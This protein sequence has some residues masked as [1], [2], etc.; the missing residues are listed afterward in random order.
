MK[1]SIITTIAVMAMT[2]A[3]GFSAF[4]ATESADYN[5]TTNLTRSYGEISFQTPASWGEPTA[6]NGAFVWT[7]PEGYVMSS[8]SA[9]AGINPN[10]ITN[11]EITTIPL[12]NMAAMSFAATNIQLGTLPADGR[13]TCTVTGTGAMN[14]TSG[15]LTY[16]IVNSSTGVY[17][18]QYFA[19]AAAGTSRL[20]DFTQVVNSINF[21]TQTTTAVATASTQ[22]TNTTKVS[23][24]YKNALK[25]AETYSNKMHMSKQAVYDQ[26]TSQYGG[27]FSADAAQY[28][29][30]NVVADWNA[31][32]LKSAETYSNKMH[33]S[34]QAVYD[35]LV[36][37]Y[38]AQFTA[39]EAQYAVNNV[40][41]DWNANAL[42][43]A[44]TYYTKMHMSKQRVYDQLVSPYGAQFTAAEAQYAIANLGD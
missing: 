5:A 15:T 11:D 7:L 3:M 29:I 44:Q 42:K 17:S 33:M 16:T 22:K 40:V 27:R 31:N 38:G 4:A 39:A 35:Q 6:A 12:T 34:K 21:G 10:V 18:M 41:A 9:Q 37:A 26:L 2:I 32:A 24:E 23:Q 13:N 36:S 14:G 25:S 20:N 1:K 30:D 8:Y 43:S 28:A 19:G